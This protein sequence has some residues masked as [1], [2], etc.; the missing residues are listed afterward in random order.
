MPSIGHHVF[1]PRTAAPPLVGV[2][3]CHV[4]IHPHSGHPI[5]DE[6]YVPKDEDA[7]CDDTVAAAAFGSSIADLGL[8]AGQR[9]RVNGT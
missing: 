4:Y 2:D 7:L 9:T 3:R 8:D 1:I 6:S 5:P